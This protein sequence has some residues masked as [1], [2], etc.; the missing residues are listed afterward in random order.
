MAPSRKT[1]RRFC[2][3]ASSLPQT[4]TLS[5]T[6]IAAGQSQWHLIE[7]QFSQSDVIRSGDPN[8]GL[9]YLYNSTTP[10]SPFEGP[11]G[12]GATTPTERQGLVTIQVIT[13][14][15]ATT[16][17]ETPPSPSEGWTPLYLVDLSYGQTTIIQSEIHQAGPSVG[18]GVPDNYQAAP[19]LAGLTNSHHGGVAGQAPQIKLASE[20]QGTLP[21]ANLPVSDTYGEIAAMQIY[22]SNPNGHVAGNAANEA[23]PPSMCWDTTGKILWTCTSTGTTAT[24]VWS[25][26]GI[27]NNV[28]TVTANATLTAENSGLVL[29]NAAPGDV[30]IN[31][32]AAASAGGSALHFRFVQFRHHRQHSDRQSRLRRHISF[33]FC[34]QLFCS[35]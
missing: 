26:V 2:S 11:N 31:L 28:T 14:S 35:D 21:M 8:G 18:T 1:Q 4:V 7:A 30:V 22:A 5:T 15:P 32:P 29:V 25:P 13:G 3:R 10:T 33:R 16:G 23:T 24:A 17:S 12:D 6:G 34:H 9:L 20:V 19:F 27:G